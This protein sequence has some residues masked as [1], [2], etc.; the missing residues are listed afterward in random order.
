[1]LSTIEKLKLLAESARYDVSCSSSGS[2]RRAPKGGFGS[3]SVSGI[4]HSWSEDGRCI[5]LLK[6]LMTNHCIYDCDYCVNR[7]SNSIER[8]LF[9]PSEI[10][11]LTVD[12]YKRNYIEGL[13]LSSG[14]FRSPDDTMLLL[15]EVARKLR[16]DEKFGGYIHIKG[17]PGASRELIETL[18]QYA[19]RVSVNIEMP[20]EKALSLYAPE[21]TMQSILQ[22]M[23]IIQ[24]GMTRYQE[25]RKK[26]KHTP[27]FVPA[28]QTTQMIIGLDDINDYT[29]LHQAQN[30]YTTMALKR[31]YYSA[32]VPIAGSKHLSHITM[33]PLLR[34]HRLYQAD[35]LMRFYRF[36][37]EELL[38]PE[39]NRFD[40]SLDPKAFW[41][42]THPD[43]FP[44]EINKAQYRELLRVPGIGPKSAQRIVS[45]RRLAPVH[46]D[47]L[48][49]IGVV[50][51]R[52]RHF[53]TVNGK[54]Y[55]SAR[56]NTSLRDALISP[57]AQPQQLSFLEEKS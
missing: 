38:T 41:A 14:V 45:A 57:A 40:E 51:K 18:G 3:T 8:A 5:S 9:S 36:R 47:H 27:R 55:G 48:K 26:I 39:H 33:A 13:F 11:H 28:G 16:L 53:I 50:L 6:I 24:D 52:A 29:I 15:I 10:V 19:D 23:A 2:T 30:L 37:A 42:I 46:Y 49:K 12:F 43:I 35:F 17:I 1:M 54:Y 31:V 7:R 4:C 21:K 20:T 25:E 34:E 44:I 32:F 22:P 56:N